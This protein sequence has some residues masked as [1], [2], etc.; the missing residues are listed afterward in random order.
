[1][2]FFIRQSFSMSD[3]NL[4][5][6]GRGLVYVGFMLRF[7]EWSNGYRRRQRAAANIRG[8]CRS[9]QVCAECGLLHIPARQFGDQWSG[10]QG[11][12]SGILSLQ[13]EGRCL[14][15]CVTRKRSILDGIVDFWSIYFSWNFR[16]F[17][18][19]C[20]GMR[21]TI[22]FLKIIQLSNNVM[23]CYA[24]FLCSLHWLVINVRTSQ[25]AHHQVTWFLPIMSIMTNAASVI[26]SSSSCVIIKYLVR[27]SYLNVFW[28]TS[29][30]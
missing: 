9:L 18:D 10:V 12:W 19:I 16:Y 11:L 8:W 20:T 3:T 21:M 24:C 27:Q 13:A 29:K 14:K 15:F 30:W 17:G 25:E 4:A 23:F 5:L 26:C 22:C 28:F 6:S 1:M 2:E 7:D